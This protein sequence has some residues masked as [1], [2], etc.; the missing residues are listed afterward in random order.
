[1]T[2]E[3]AIQNDHLVF[4][5]GL[6]GPFE[7]VRHSYTVAGCVKIGCDK[8]TSILIC[9]MSG[10]EQERDIIVVGKQCMNRILQ[11]VFCA[12][13]NDLLYVK[14]GR[15]IPVGLHK[16]RNCNRV[17]VTPMEIATGVIIETN[18][19]CFFMV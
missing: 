13:I 3:A 5:F 17:V 12:G 8:V 14:V 1:M 2:G 9:A 15:A 6:I 7:D 18:N 19:K 10:E 11:L 16:A 4:A